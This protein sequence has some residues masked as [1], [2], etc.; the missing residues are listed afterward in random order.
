MIGFVLWAGVLLFA[1]YQSE[2]GPTRNFII[3]AIALNLFALIVAL[4]MGDTGPFQVLRAALGSARRRLPSRL[5]RRK[6]NASFLAHGTALPSAALGMGAPNASLRE[7][8]SP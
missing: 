2:P 7:A 4:V 5:K 8:G 1:L 6:I 3:F